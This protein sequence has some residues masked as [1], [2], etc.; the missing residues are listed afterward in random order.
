MPDPFRITAPGIYPDIASA[1]YFADPCPAPSL[2]QSVAKVLLDRSPLHA[3]HA[4]PRL[5]PDY[6]HDDDTKFDVGNI[7]HSLMLG[8]GK[9]IT[10]L[11]FDNWRT[12]AAKEAREAAA[13]DGS[14]A[15]LR[16]H[17]TKADR[18]V[19]AAREQMELRG[20]AKL[21]DGRH[22]RGE[23][24]LAWQEGD[25]WLRQLV[26][27]LSTD[28]RIFC[29]FKTTDMSAAPYG[30]SRMMVSAGWPIQAAMAERGLD[31]LD[32][33]GAG[34]RTFLFVVQEAD[35]PYGLNV[36]EVGEAALTM[37]RKMIEMAVAI[38]RDC[39]QRDRWPGYPLEVITP[40]VPGWHETQ[41]L[42]REMEHAERAP[43][44]TD[45]SGG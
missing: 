2:T 20:L 38:W 18:M 27:W 12:K 23:I 21:F 22:G 37:G 42:T 14:L 26:D 28:Q 30:L 8:R 41:V 40:E 5:N 36:V 13:A 24:C 44:L 11:D 31:V 3:W 35:A 4:H 7:A 10:V 29:D 25:I 33:E 16:K 39:L 19:R 17:F 45:L 43:M 15:V 9:Q 34:R 1:D 32:P 6:R